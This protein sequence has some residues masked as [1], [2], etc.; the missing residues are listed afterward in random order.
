M[1]HALIVVPYYFFTSLTL[2]TL[3]VLVARVLGLKVSI[4]VFVYPAIVL[5]ALAVALFLMSE[6][7]SLH[8][9]KGGPMVGLMLLSMALGAIDFLVA[10]S[11]PLPLDKE[12]RDDNPHP[13]G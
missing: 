7:G 13:V 12:L 5:G 9:L 1:L 11:R 6:G 3:F 10:R 4:N 2:L 8:D